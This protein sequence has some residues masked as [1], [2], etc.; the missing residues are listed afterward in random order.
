M[1]L[2][3]ILLSSIV[4]HINIFYVIIEKKRNG[5]YFMKLTITNQFQEFLLGIGIN[6]EDLLKKA[7]IPINYGRRK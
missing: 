5:E 6:I 4:L 1:S 7:N 2:Y 3:D